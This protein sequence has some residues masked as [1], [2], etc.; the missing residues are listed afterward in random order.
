MINPNDTTLLLID[1][2]SGLFNLV[3]DMS[4]PDLRRNVTA[5]AKV[6]TLLKLLQRDFSTNKVL[7][8]LWRSAPA[9]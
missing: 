6:A 9:V 2:Q 8:W 5:L 1:H 7:C 3:K 4:V